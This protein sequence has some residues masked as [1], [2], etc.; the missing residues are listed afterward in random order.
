MCVTA[1]FNTVIVIFDKFI[2]QDNHRSYLGNI[3]RE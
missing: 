2:T 3:Y 1:I